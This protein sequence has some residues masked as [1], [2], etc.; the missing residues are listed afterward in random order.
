MRLRRE[1][2]ARVDKRKKSVAYSE[3]F[4]WYAS[5]FGGDNPAEYLNHYRNDPLPE[6]Y[7][8]NWITY[9]WALNAKIEDK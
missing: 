6:N 8:V 7:S 1:R 9:D 4:K 2:A 5:D 3:L